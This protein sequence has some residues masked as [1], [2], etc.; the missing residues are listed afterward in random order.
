MFFLIPYTI[1]IFTGWALWTK[2]EFISAKDCVSG[3]AII[4]NNSVYKCEEVQRL[5]D[6]PECNP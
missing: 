1:V 2:D 4:H 5:C 6:K 3:K